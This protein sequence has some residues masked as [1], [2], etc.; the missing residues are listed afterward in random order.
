MKTCSP[1]RPGP[2]SGIYFTTSPECV[3]HVTFYRDFSHRFYG[4]DRSFPALPIFSGSCSSIMMVKKPGLNIQR[5]DEDAGELF[6]N[7]A[8]L[9]DRQ[10]FFNFIITTGI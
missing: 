1:M 9:F 4:S 5:A 10:A 7:F 6:D 3:W 2:G 8:F